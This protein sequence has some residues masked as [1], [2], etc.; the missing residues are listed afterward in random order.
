MAILIYHHLVYLRW[1]KFFRIHTDELVVPNIDL[2]HM[3]D[4]V[5]SSSV[6]EIKIETNDKGNDDE[7]KETDI[8]S[9]DSFH[10]F[11]GL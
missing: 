9:V 4:T 7:N 8:A 5:M 3:I 6:I 1:I 10:V 11:V 2:F